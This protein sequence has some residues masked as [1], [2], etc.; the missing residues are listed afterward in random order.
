MIGQLAFHRATISDGVI[1]SVAFWLANPGQEYRSPKRQT[2]RGIE[3]P[4]SGAIRD[5]HAGEDMNGLLA[6]VAENRDRAAFQALF[7]FFAPRIK[8]FMYRQGTSPDMAEEVLQEAM[9]NV[10]RKA[11]QFDPAKASASTWI[12]TIARNAR[13][14]HLRRASSRPYDDVEEL[15]IA[16]TE[17]NAEDS[18]LFGQQAGRIAEALVELPDDQREV[19]ELAFLSDMPQVEIA[20]KLGLPL[21]TVKSRMRLAYGKLR[22]KLE[23]LK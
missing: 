21:G 22:I 16:S 6:A 11:G 12:F 14:D 13:I 5:E 20:A 17:R 8:A 4:M 3:A 2:V 19:I 7:E 18:T 23:D 9:V 15:E 1:E 10:W